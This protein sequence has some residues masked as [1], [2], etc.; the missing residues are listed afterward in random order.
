MYP[1]YEGPDQASLAADD[2]AGLCHLYPSDPAT[3][4][5]V[6]GCPQ[7]RHCTELGCAVDSVPATA[8]NLPGFDGAMPGHQA[9]DTDAGQSCLLGFCG[10]NSSPLG[11]PCLSAHDCASRACSDDG[12]CVD[13]CKRGS[14]DAGLDGGVDGGAA[15]TENA[16]PPDSHCEPLNDHTSFVCIGPRT[17]GAQCKAASDCYGGECV[18]GLTAQPFCTRRCGA[19]YPSCPDKWQCGSVDG[20]SVC[21]F[22]SRTASC[23]VAVVGAGAARGLA[24]G[25]MF[26]AATLLARRRRHQQ[27]VAKRGPEKS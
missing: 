16:C 7:G 8:L 24:T 11:D 6:A 12:Q 14:I 20:K 2:I 18:T 22:K 15:S 13:P 19:E 5:A 17:I 25:F 21:T 27:F 1:F 4:C 10:D 26:I 9:S 23:Q 3:R